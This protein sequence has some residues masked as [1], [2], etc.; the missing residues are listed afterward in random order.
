MITVYTGNGK[1]KT[2]S[3]LSEAL[4]SLSENKKVVMIQL[5]KGST[6]SG[7]LTAL[8]RLGI[9]LLQFG[10]GCRWSSMIRSGLKHCTNCGECFRANR[11]PDTALFL[12]QKAQDYLNKIVRNQEF[13]LIILDEISHALNYGFLPLEKLLQLLREYD[14]IDWILTGRKM[15]IELLTIADSWW[16]LKEDKHPF[17]QGLPSR[18]GIE[19]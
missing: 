9:P 13:D 17:R 14:N 11:D 8:Y 3:A 16:E 4:F 7:E 12:I 1:G 10:V 2:T 18:R 5:L 6:Y 15:P 19:Y